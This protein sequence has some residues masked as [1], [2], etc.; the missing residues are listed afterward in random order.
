M[1]T[2]AVATQTYMQLWADGYAVLRDDD[3][4]FVVGFSDGS[5]V[6]FSL[7]GQA[8][9]QFALRMMFGHPTLKVS[10]CEGDVMNMHYDAGPKAKFVP[11]DSIGSPGDNLMTFCTEVIALHTLCLAQK[12]SKV[13]RC[14]YGKKSQVWT[15]GNLN[16]Y[17][18]DHGYA[19]LAGCG[20]EAPI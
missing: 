5:L 16:D 1:K 15:V 12:K 20:Q 17:A 18:Y 7:F 10:V 11:L 4:F 6:M 3:E 19:D 13:V 9:M 2:D 8:F 14:G